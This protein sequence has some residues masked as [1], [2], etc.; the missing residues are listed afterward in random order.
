MDAT[1][2][3]V[4]LIVTSPNFFTILNKAPLPIV[5][6]IPECPFV[7]VWIAR[8]QSIYI[9]APSSVISIT[10][11]MKRVDHMYTISHFNLFVSS[12]V[13]FLTRVQ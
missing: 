2:V 3:L 8:D 10:V 13:E 4:K 5:V 7:S 12:S 11:G 6:N 9:I 1:P